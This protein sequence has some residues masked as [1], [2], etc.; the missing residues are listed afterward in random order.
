MGN[1]GITNTTSWV[2]KKHSELTGKNLTCKGGR[3]EGGM[4]LKSKT[5]EGRIPCEKVWGIRSSRN[6]TGK[7]K[8]GERRIAGNQKSPGEGGGR[9]PMSRGTNS[10]RLHK[11]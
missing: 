5:W 1:R 10:Y 6:N 4:T 9:Y 11:A 2:L 7:K 8:S 3:I